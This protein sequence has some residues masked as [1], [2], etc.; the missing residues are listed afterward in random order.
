MH[1]VNAEFQK[2]AL[3]KP[4]HLNREEFGIFFSHLVN[5]DESQLNYYFILFDRNRDGFVSEADLA[6]GSLATSPNVPFALSA[7]AVSLRRQFV[8]A[9]RDSK[10]RGI[11]SRDDVVKMLV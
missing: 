5:Y 7:S 9:A 8:F 1:I 3:A 6:A 4:R 11:M 2:C 10:R